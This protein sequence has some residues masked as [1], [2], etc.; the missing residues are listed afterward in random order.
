MGFRL[1]LFSKLSVLIVDA[2]RILLQDGSVLRRTVPRVQA[3]G[4]H[5]TPLLRVKLQ[6]LHLHTE[7]SMMLCP[8]HLHFN[9]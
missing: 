1:V 7:L 2:D 8:S 6:S 3:G 9:L 5:W 4:G